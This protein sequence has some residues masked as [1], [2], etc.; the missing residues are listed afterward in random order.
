M[1]ERK[2]I[3][4]VGQRR[5]LLVTFGETKVTNNVV[6]VKILTNLTAYKSQTEKYPKCP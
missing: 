5:M 6:I 4:K 3:S 2:E 1:N